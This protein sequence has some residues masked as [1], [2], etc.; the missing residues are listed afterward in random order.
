[1]RALCVASRDVQPVLLT[2]ATAVLFGLSFPPVGAAPL[3]WVSLVPFLVALA[4]VPPRR[5]AALALLLA[6]AGA[7]G[8]TWWFAAMVSAYFGS[9]VL[10]GGLAWLVF[11][12]ASVGLQLVPFAV[13]TSWMA[14]RGAASPLLVAAA[15]T[16]C[17]LLRARLW[18]GNPW[19]LI[20]YS[21]MSWLPAVQLADLAGPYGPGT[22]LA[23]VNAALAALAAPAL[24]GPHFRWSLSAVALLA[25]GTIGYGVHRLA[26]P[27][28]S[29]DAVRVALVQP[30]VEAEERRTEAGNARAIA[31]QLDAT[32]RAAANGSRLVVWPENAVP[33]HLEEASPA[34]DA[35]LSALRDLDVDVI[36][37]GRRTATR[38]TASAIATPS[39]CCVAGRW[40]DDTTR[41][42]CCRSPKGRTSQGSIPYALRTRAGLVGALRLLRGHVSG[43][44]P[45]NRDRRPDP[46]R[47]PLERRVVRRRGARSPAPRHGADARHRGTALAASSHH[48]RHLGHRRSDRP[49]GGGR[50]LRD[51]GPAGGGGLPAADRHPLSALGRPRWRGVQ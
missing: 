15:W 19:G 23:A 50:G 9:G 13:W 47:E 51:A 22:V 31:F 12:T 16:A 20:A 18:V 36:M 30:A 48:H 34:R 2:L 49:G 39:T 10:L 14:R 46:P 11:C 35:L 7:L 38:S 33:F 32:R 45:P 42:A 37:G 1:M 5:A 24:R 27:P 17:E 28:G 40:Q 44:D 41:C 26:T 3:A 29:G 21:Q 25:A 43:A 6:P 8:I 4:R